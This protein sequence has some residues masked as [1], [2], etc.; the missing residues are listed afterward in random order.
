MTPN[1]T[2]SPRA[3]FDPQAQAASA[4]TGPSTV[5][6]LYREFYRDRLSWLALAISAVLLC[7][8]GGAVMFWFHAV[9]LG[10]GGPA[11][12]WYAHM[13]LDSTFGFLALT[14]ALILIMPLAVAAGGA[15]AG[16]ARAR[17]VPVLYAVLSGAMFALVTVPGPIAHNTFVARG[18]WLA[19]QATRMIGDPSAPLPPV[20]HYPVLAALTQQ[21]GFGLPLYVALSAAAVLLVRWL[22]AARSGGWRLAQ[23]TGGPRTAP[24]TGGASASW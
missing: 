21:L 5:F 16:A 11:I 15:L 12:S 6:R 8:G 23:E 18:T 2:A 3:V 13:L 9:A 10:E 24:G 22:V 19:D 14:P 17:L 4:G 1:S 7:Y 20:H